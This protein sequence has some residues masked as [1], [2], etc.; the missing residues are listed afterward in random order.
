MNW[1][2]AY[3]Q[4]ALGTLFAA[5]GL[6][7]LVLIRLKT[8]RNETPTVPTAALPARPATVRVDV[9]FF[10]YFA[11]V[12][13]GLAVAAAAPSPWSLLGILAAV[14]ALVPFTR[15]VRSIRDTAKGKK[16]V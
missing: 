16:T 6:T 13:Y 15:A 4:L 1:S 10:F 11:A 9:R 5:I 3:F 7:F 2:D 12:F 8:A 14:I